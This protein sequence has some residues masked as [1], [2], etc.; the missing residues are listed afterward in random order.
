[1]SSPTDPTLTPAEVPVPFALS[2]RVADGR[3]ILNW[4]LSAADSAQVATFIVYRID[5]LNAVP[6]YLDDVAW[7]PYVDA[8]AINGTL[9]AYAVSVRN[10]DGIEGQ[11]STAVR[12][13][14]RFVSVQINEDSL[15]TRSVDVRLSISAA[16]AT[17]MR[18]GHD[19]LQ[20]SD[21]RDFTAVATWTL[22]PNAGPKA[23][24]AQFQFADG[25][26][27]DGWVSDSITLDDRAQ[28]YSLTLSDSVLAPGDSLVVTLEARETD[29]T[30]SFDLGSRSGIRL[31]DDGIAPDQAAQDGRYTAV[32][33]ASAGD[34]FEQSEVR[35]RFTDAAGNRAADFTSAWKVSVRQPPEP[36]V[37]VGI[38]ATESDPTV[39]NLS[40]VRVTS[41]PFSQLF[42]RRS[43]TS[44]AGAGAPIV[45]IFSSPSVTTHRDTGLV[46]ATTYYYWLEVV[47]TNGQ[48]A[49]SAQASGV[50]PSDLPPDP[51]LVAVTPT[52]DSSMLLS[53]TQSV[54]ADFESY[55]VYR[56]LT[57]TALNPSPPA[58]SLL[59]SVI[60]TAAATTYAESGQSRSYYYRVF[61]FDHAG[62]RSG[63]NVVWGPKDFGPP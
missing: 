25:A 56:A 32:Y 22:L 24:F 27:F 5:S 34:L 8:T 45:A 30:A 61:V 49:I 35:G 13:Q 9:Y 39:L 38:V 1:V 12:A 31:Y 29:G 14:P 4:T 58:D 26:Q 59:V 46:G 37:W 51:V 16:G 50:T 3:V 53:W 47:L 17:L 42:L 33:V 36:P 28:I 23:V 60:T 62:Q 41:E 6:R 18:F 40:W 21:W 57:S 44:G 10:H 15:F 20:P 7:P 54:A 52:A 63:S 2:A 43:T 55:R 48:R 19:T 11:K